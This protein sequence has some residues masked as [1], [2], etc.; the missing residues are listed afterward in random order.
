MATRSSSL[1][2]T[3]LIAQAMSEFTSLVR[4]ELRLA[5]AEMGEKISGLGNA[6]VMLAIGVVASLGSVLVL[7]LGA[8]EWLSRAGIPHRWGFLLVGIVGIVIG[9]V[10]MLKAMGRLRSTTVLP[11]RTIH[12]FK[13]DISTAKEQAK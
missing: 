10:S 12:Q 4:S 9:L 1:P 3:A 6:A 7:M 8:V 11:D 13:A 2:L 5:Q